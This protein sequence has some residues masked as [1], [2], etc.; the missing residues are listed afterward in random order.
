M[1]Q[2]VPSNRKLNCLT[3]LIELA[4]HFGAHNQSLDGTRQIVERS[5][6]NGT[7]RD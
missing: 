7:R 1:C 3:E 6:V 4:R 5:R 2:S